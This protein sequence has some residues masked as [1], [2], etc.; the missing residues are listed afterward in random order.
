MAIKVQTISISPVTITT[1]GPFSATITNIEP[2]PSDNFVGRVSG[3]NNFQ[4]SW[5]RNGTCRGSVHDYNIDPE[6]LAFKELVEFFDSI[7]DILN[8]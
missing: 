5:D 6:S 8:G 3:L 1:K 7:N 2:G 4:G